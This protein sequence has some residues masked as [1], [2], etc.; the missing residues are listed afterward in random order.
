MADRLVEMIA[1]KTRPIIRGM[2]YDLVDIEFAKEGVNRY[3]RF[4]IEH[5]DVDLPVTTDDCQQVSE[6]LSVWLDEADPIPQAYFLE[7]SSPG[8]ERPLKDQRDYD[9]FLGRMVLVETSAPVEGE[10]S[11][12]GHLGPATGKGLVL[13]QKDRELSIPADVI[14]GARLYWMEEDVARNQKDK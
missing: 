13:K 14:S 10:V 1:E 6:R 2:D 11:H 8:L 4:F 3:L 7:V 9:R 12:I 5:T